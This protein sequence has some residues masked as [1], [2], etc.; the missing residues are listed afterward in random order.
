ML[1]EVLVSPSAL[2]QALASL[3]VL[4]SD[5]TDASDPSSA[6][7]CTDESSCSETSS[8]DQK[9]ILKWYL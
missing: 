4:Q 3:A 5:T 9:E 2:E 1:A 8:I 6:P 7:H